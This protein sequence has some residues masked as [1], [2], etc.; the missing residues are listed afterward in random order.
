MED[1]YNT[2]IITLGLICLPICSAEVVYRAWDYG[3]SSDTDA[4]N[5][6]CIIYLAPDFCGISMFVD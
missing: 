4:P 5:Y 3:D 2:D 1:I 6:L